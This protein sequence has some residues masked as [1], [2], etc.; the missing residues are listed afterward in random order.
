[1]HSGAVEGANVVRSKS[2]SESIT[3]YVEMVGG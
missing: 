1:M 3:L 2:D